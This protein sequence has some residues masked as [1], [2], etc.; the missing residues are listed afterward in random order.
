MLLAFLGLAVLAAVY[1]RRRPAAGSGWLVASFGALTTVLALGYLELTPEAGLAELAVHKL[2]VALIVAFPYCLYRFMRTFL[3]ARTVPAA[4]AHGS[5]AIALLGTL[6]APGPL[7]LESDASFV[8]VATA[9]VV[10]AQFVAVS[11]IAAVRLWTAGDAQPPVARGR[12]R[13]LGAGVIAVSVALLVAVVAEG[14]TASLVPQVI[15]LAAGV[16]CLLGFAPP[17][18]IRTVWRR[19]A[20]G[21]VREAEEA[22]ATALTPEDVAAALLPAVRD[23][24]SAEAAALV[25]DDGAVIGAV[26]ADAHRLP[27]RT[28]DPRVLVGELRTGS[29]LVAGNRFAPYYG[30]DERQL[31]A[32]F[33]TVADLALER[34]ELFGQERSAR[35]QIETAHAELEAF[36]YG[37][38]HDLKN[39]IITLLGYAELLNSDHGDRLDDEGRHFLQ[40]MT[41][42]AEY[43]HELLNDLLE[44]SRIGRV[45]TEPETVDLTAIATAVA[46]ETGRAHPA[47]TVHVDELPAVHMNAVRV[48]Q[49]LTNLVEN[50]VKHGGRD[51]ITVTVSTGDDAPPGMARVIV[52]DDGVG[53]PPEHHDRV[54]G[55]FERLGEGAYGDGGGT[56]I[57]LSIC[58]RIAEV[59]GGSIGLGEPETGTEVHLDLLLPPNVRGEA[60]PGAGDRTGS[61]YS[62]EAGP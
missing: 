33:G 53:I 30:D 52:A 21:V 25:D 56:G 26:G 50:A 54:F 60:G 31:L 17:P 23:A 61:H 24:F 4:V 13:M 38:S 9:W 10:V 49:L 20:D 3:P 2:S 55:M 62:V 1:W 59:A 16:L 29:L 47:V 6:V 34:A 41:A 42:S 7:S 37:I 48:R 19:A 46:E 43:M 44:L 5:T 27:E 39:P 14:P 15:A 35:A 22:I 58:R 28:D 18:I 11:L 12:M 40:R 8:A 32:T 57:G 36:V 51:D 45:Q